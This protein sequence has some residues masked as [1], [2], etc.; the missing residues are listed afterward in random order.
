MAQKQKQEIK[1]VYV[2]EFLKNEKGIPS[3]VRG[4]TWPTRETV[5]IVMDNDCE[6]A[7]NARRRTFAQWAKGFSYQGT[8]QKLEPGGMVRL[9]CTPL[10]SSKDGDPQY[11]TDWIN[12]ITRN[13]E[14]TSEQIKFA[15]VQGKVRTPIEVREKRNEIRQSSAMVKM[16]KEYKDEHGSPM[17]P[18]I[19]N[20]EIERRLAE[21]MR[22]KDRYHMTYYSYDPNDC[23]RGH[24]KQMIREKL[25]QY[26]SDGQ[27]EPR[28]TKDDVEYRPIKPHLIIRGVNEE[29]QYVGI[30]AEFM[31]GDDMRVQRDA[32]GRVISRECLSPEECADIVIA[33]LPRGCAAW[34]I[35]PA[36]VYTHSLEQMK[37]GSN[38]E[39]AL[40]QAY[41]L[42]AD[43]HIQT[44]E[45]APPLIRAF[46]MGLKVSAGESRVVTEVLRV[47]GRPP[48]DPVLL[49]KGGLQLE[50]APA[51]AAKLENSASGK[52]QKEFEANDGEDE[53]ASP[54]M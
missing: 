49:E 33:H 16:A 15:W 47:Y 31:P 8:T 11:K 38:N 41:A 3:G 53:T 40:R 17:P 22:G 10:D 19:V 29:G 35:L 50:L 28:Y 51:Y 34:N 43:C 37:L 32:E 14:Q 2:Q 7:Q 12:V 30:R 27:F 6:K 5:S 36:R 1:Y 23:I 44:E 52:G 42:N 26:F 48:V 21:A 20:R 24:D 9:R 13:K 39:F 54:C 46:E 18:E 4:V 45:G 25:L